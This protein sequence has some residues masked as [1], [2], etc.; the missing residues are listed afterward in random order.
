MLHGTGIFTYMWL[1]FMVNVGKYNSHM[2]A[3][4]LVFWSQKLAG[5]ERPRPPGNRAP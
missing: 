4:G 3:M 5:F 1:M 2:D